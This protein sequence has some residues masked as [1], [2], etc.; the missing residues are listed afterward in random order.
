MSDVNVAR[1]TTDK[2][3]RKINN[4]KTRIPPFRYYFVVSFY[5]SAFLIV[6]DG[7]YRSDAF[8]TRLRF[9][10]LITNGILLWFPIFSLFLLLS[11]FLWGIDAMVFV[12]FFRKFKSNDSGDINFFN[13]ISGF[14]YYSVFAWINIIYFRLCLSSF[15]PGV[16]KDGKLVGIG[17]IV[18]ILLIAAL[19]VYIFS[20]R[21]TIHDAA[22]RKSINNL[23]KPVFIVFI[24]LCLVFVSVVLFE[25]KGKGMR[26]GNNKGNKEGKPHILFITLD[27]LRAANMSLHGY[28][29]KT[30]PFLEKFA[31]ECNE[32]FPC[33]FMGIY[34][35]NNDR[36]HDN[37]LMEQQEMKALIEKVPES[38]WVKYYRNF[39]ENIK[40]TR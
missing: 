5:I 2:T 24:I 40:T 27:N 28:D 9:L 39:Q 23:F 7:I 26:A 34:D 30:T 22:F 37:N 10:Q 18:S 16:M 13:Y 32:E 14:I 3:E 21:K 11:L 38:Q 1:N 31:D 15:V 25:W 4:F 20:V 8:L 29:V 12:I 36:L 17:S 19:F 6:L 33:N 35:M